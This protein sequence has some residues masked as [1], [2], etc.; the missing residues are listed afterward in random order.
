MALS[1]PAV[2]HPLPERRDPVAAAIASLRARQWSKNLLVF[3]GILFAAELGDAGRWIAAIAAFLAYCAASSAAYLLNDVRDRAHDRVHPV[4]RSR[5]VAR[6]E[7]SAGAALA[8]AGTLALA[9]AALT[10][11]L[12]LGPLALLAGFVAVQAG[13]SYGL[14]HVVLVDVMAIAALFTIRA[15]AGAEAV[16]VPISPWLLLCTALLALFLA[17]AKRRGE[18]VLVGADATPGRPVL[19]GYSVALVDQLVSVVAASAIIAY[20]IYTV[21]AHSQ[22]MMA[23]IP[24]VV[25]GIFRYLLLVHRRDLGEEPENVLLSDWP[26]LAT[27]A[28]WALTCA[29]VLSLL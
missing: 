22:A 5:P 12:G 26:T 10:A 3:A 15:A 13:Y 19:E 14:K 29:L 8:L 20:A 25:F 23:T 1:E 16:D 21:S 2:V 6:G 17:L 11:P 28:A 9:A 4:K 24:F 7:L 27:V 18:L